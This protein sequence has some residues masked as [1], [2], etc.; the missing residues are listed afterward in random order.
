MVTGGGQAAVAAV[1]EDE[2]LGAGAERARA[3]DPDDEDGVVGVG[4]DLADS[5]LDRRDRG[6]QD[7]TDLVEREAEPL[8]RD[9]ERDAEERG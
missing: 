6:V 9:D 5:A 7:A 8:G 4:P 2:G 1:V 3:G